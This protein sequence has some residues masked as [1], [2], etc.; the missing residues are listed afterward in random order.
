MKPTTVTKSAVFCAVLILC[1]FPL[2]NL[3]RSVRGDVSLY[4]HDLLLTGWLALSTL[5][6][7]FE[8]RSF[9][10]QSTRIQ[11]FLL[12]WTVFNLLFA[13][14]TQG[15]L[16]PILYA[17][18]VL[19]YCIGGWT[20]LRALPLRLS[21]SFVAVT[22]LVYQVLA[23]LLYL[24]MPDMRF[25]WTHGWDDHYYRVIGT[26]FDPAFTGVLA[27]LTGLFIWHKYV[28]EKAKRWPFIAF[29]AS[30]IVLT[31]SRASYLA[32]L[33]VVAFLVRARGRQAFQVGMVVV[34]TLGLL[35]WVFPKPGGEGVDLL[36]TASIK[37]RLEVAATSV[38]N[39]K[40]HTFVTGNGLFTRYA[41]SQNPDMPDSTAHFPDNIILLVFLQTGVPGLLLWVLVLGEYFKKLGKSHEL[42]KATLLT[43][44][45]HAQFNNTIF[46]P[47]VLLYV[48][49]ILATDDR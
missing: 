27:I 6:R 22:G 17:A 47:F 42:S 25:L 8:W 40:W 19:V 10:A 23:V 5:T 4:P 15:S 46:Q 35:W 34:I 26:L 7:R 18:R 14:L 9:F 13:V 16:V 36:R 1:S 33:A 48:V 24:W 37:A 3:L 49:W 12:G 43:V 20:L 21:T 32:A 30:N 44:L 31:F 11:Q 41:P 39:L 38:Q 45:V 28:H 29:L 2:G